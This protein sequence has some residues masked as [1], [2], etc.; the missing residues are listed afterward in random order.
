MKMHEY[1]KID[2]HNNKINFVTI[3]DWGLWTIVTTEYG[4]TGLLTR[5]QRGINDGSIMGQQWINSEW[6]MH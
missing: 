4:S 1:D 6:M 3:E 2:I 5:D